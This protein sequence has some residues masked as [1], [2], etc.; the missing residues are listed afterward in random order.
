VS[1][2]PSEILSREVWQLPLLQLFRWAKRTR[3]ADVF[4]KSG[5]KVLLGLGK[6]N[7]VFGLEIDGK[8]AN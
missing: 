7:E 4:E 3:I 6:R 5:R 8:T 1:D 2:A